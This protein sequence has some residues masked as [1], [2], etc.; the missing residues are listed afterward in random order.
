MLFTLAQAATTVV[1]TVTV[2]PPNVPVEIVKQPLVGWEPRDFSGLVLAGLSLVVSIAAIWFSLKS[3]RMQGPVAKIRFQ[4]F[5]PEF[6]VWLSIANVGRETGLLEPVVVSYTKDFDWCRLPIEAFSFMKEPKSRKMLMPGEY[7]AGQV[8]IREF[9]TVM[10][11]SDLP[12]KKI[13][14]QVWFAGKDLSIK[15]PRKFR[16]RIEPYVL[17]DLGKLR[18]M[19]NNRVV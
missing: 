7:I 10:R 11:E 19:G 2:T 12:L 18:G 4:D 6:G 15:V 1:V 16:R 3:W 9:A 13:G 17:A 14:I 5:E 8:S